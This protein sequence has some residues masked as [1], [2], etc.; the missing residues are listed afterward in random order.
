M[1]TN[2]ILYKIAGAKMVM[3]GNETTLTCLRCFK[4]LKCKT[5]TIQLLTMA[6][7]SFKAVSVLKPILIFCLDHR[8]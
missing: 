5:V 1:L 7:V 3:V 8:V 6:V 2:T 4:K